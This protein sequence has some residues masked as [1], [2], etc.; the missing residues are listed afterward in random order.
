M[1]DCERPASDDF[2]LGKGDI[3]GER[4][5]EAVKCGLDGLRM[6]GGGCW[7]IRLRPLSGL[8]ERI[9]LLKQTFRGQLMLQ[10]HVWNKHAH[11]STLT[12]Q[13]TRLFPPRMTHLASPSR[14]SP[15]IV[16]AR[17]SPDRLV[18]LV[19]FCKSARQAVLDVGDSGL[20]RFLGICSVGGRCCD[21]ALTPG[22][23]GIPSTD[24]I[25]CEGWRA[26]GVCDGGVTRAGEVWTAGCLDVAVSASDE[27]MP[28]LYAPSCN[29]PF[30]VM[31]SL[32][33]LPCR[34]REAPSAVAFTCA[35][36]TDA[37]V[38]GGSA[39]GGSVGL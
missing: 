23:A 12:S 38:S 18:R 6:G 4:G 39:G 24:S 17:S 21:S 5:C 28:G 13:Q 34:V 31:L 7:R 25:A 35:S 27:H 3:C 14:S 8:G 33:S 19:L 10:Y 16:P 32:A 20:E 11:A 9:G 36:Q 30:E 2:R 37:C 15:A 22:S 26:L 29:A 1:K